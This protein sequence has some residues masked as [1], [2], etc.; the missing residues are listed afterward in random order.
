M[1]Y[2]SG[3]DK[4][5]AEEGLAAFL[6]YARRDKD[7]V[8]T[9][10]PTFDRTFGGLRGVVCLVGEPKACKSTFALQIAVHNA[11]LGN[12]VLYIDRENGQQPMLVRFTAHVCGMTEQ[13]LLR[14]SDDERAD[15]YRRLSELPIAL[16]THGD[17]TPEDIEAR[18]ALMLET[19]PKDGNVVVVLDSLHKLPMIAD[20]MR[21]SIDAWVMFL[22]KLKRDNDGRLTVITTCEKR[23][24]TYGEPARDAAKESGRI[25]YTAEQ[26]YD[27][28]KLPDS[29]DIQITGTTSRWGNEGGKVFVEKVFKPGSGFVYALKEA[30]CDPND[31]LL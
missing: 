8:T 14:A 3:T 6:S 30:V 24:G 26:L 22:D 15:A 2:R 7:G 9:G 19:T 18:I 5:G 4:L 21:T 20:N 13:R 12:Q 23:R 1:T 11:K 27:L 31:S 29:Y 25:E 17:F 10:I 16:W 28:M